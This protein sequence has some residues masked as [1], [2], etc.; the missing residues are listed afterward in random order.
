MNFHWVLPS[1]CALLSPSLSIS[2]LPLKLESHWRN[3]AFGRAPFT[4][5][6]PDQHL[7]V[8]QL[9]DD[10]SRSYRLLEWRVASPPKRGLAGLGSRFYRTIP[11]CL[12]FRDKLFRNGAAPS[13]LPDRPSTLIASRWTT[14]RLV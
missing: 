13:R 9:R 2:P 10:D 8:A 7:L 12:L 6:T 14:N 4:F 1:F 5:Q 11:D 3:P